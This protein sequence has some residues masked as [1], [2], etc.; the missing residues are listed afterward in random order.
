MSELASAVHP[1]ST[2]D[3][4]HRCKNPPDA[5]FD[6]FMGDRFAPVGLPDTAADR[7]PKLR[8]L[9]NQSKSGI[10]NKF[11]GFCPVVIRDLRY[12]RFLLGSEVYFHSS[13]RTGL[14]DGLVVIVARNRPVKATR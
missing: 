6:I 11:L 8:V 9:F 12:L 1:I 3:R 10:F 5:R 13:V 4:H 14:W 2:M 7:G